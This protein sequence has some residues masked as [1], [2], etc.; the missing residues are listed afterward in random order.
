MLAP[1]KQ[2]AKELGREADLRLGDAQALEFPDESFD[3]DVITVALC[4][5]PDERQAVPSTAK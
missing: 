5:I 1:A 3:M 2:R 4:T